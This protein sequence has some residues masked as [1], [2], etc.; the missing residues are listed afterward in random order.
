M[1][2]RCAS[3]K[4]NIRSKHSRRTVPISR[5]TYGFCHGHPG[6]IG[7]SRIPIALTVI[8]AHQVGRRAAPWKCLG[9]LAGQPLGGRVP[10]HLKPHQLPSAMTQNQEC[11]QPVEGQGWDHAEINRCYCLRVVPQERLPALRAW[12]SSSTNHVSGD[13]GL[14]DLE[15][16]HQQFAMDPR[17][18]PRRIVPAHPPDQLP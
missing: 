6:E 2:R 12:R 5:S 4:T 13:G 18:P 8:V 11:I 14:R 15:P 17:C 1:R 7:R 10:R 16:Q 9:D 3:P